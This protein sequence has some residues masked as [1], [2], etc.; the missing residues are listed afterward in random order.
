MGLMQTFRRRMPVVIIFLIVMFVALFIY[1]WGY[2]RSG[3][4]QSGGTSTTAIASVNGEDISIAE[5]NE[6]VKNAIEA[7]RGQNA[8]APV[9]EEQI[10]E[11]VWQQLVNQTIIR[12]AAERLGV[13]VS[14]EELVQT[15]LYDPPA[16]LKQ[17]F[18]DST[19][20]FFMQKE[21]MAFMTNIDGWLAARK[22]PQN[23]IDEVKAQIKEIERN[24]MYQK[25]VEAVM[26]V[27]SSSATPSPLEARIAYSDQHEKVSGGFV[28]FDVNLIPDSAVSVTEQEAKAYYDAHRTDFQQKASREARYTLFQLTPSANDSNVMSNRLKAVTD[29]INRAATPEEKTKAF[30]QFATKY[31]S[32]TYNGVEYTPLQQLSPELQTALANAV[33]GSVIGPVRLADGSYMINVVDVKDSG[34]VYVKASHI[35][36]R[37][38]GANDDSVKAEAERI[39][40]L[41][42]GGQDFGSLATQY[43]ADPGSAQRGGDLPFFKKGSMLKEFEDASFAAQPGQIVGPVKT[44]VGYH[45]IKVTDRSSKSYR[46]RDMKFDPKVSPMTK[47]QLRTKA[48]QFR[49]KLLAG[50][51]IDTLA[52]QLK[53]QVLETGPAERLTPA[54]G[55]MRFTRFIFDE[56]Q[57]AISDVYELQDGSFL[58]GQISKIRTAGTQDFADAKDAIMMKLRAKKKLDMVKGRAEKMRAALAAGDSLSK[59]AS[60]DSS[61]QVRPINEA[62]RTTPFPGVGFDYTL[63]NALFSMKP[64]QI[65]NALRGERGYFIATVSNITKPSDKDYEAER[66]KFI[67][68]LMQQRRQQIFQEWM[69]K[70]RDRAEIIDY[71]NNR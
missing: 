48:Q 41:A 5:Y 4:G 52:T 53:L 55:S 16:A 59:L 33:P 40:K 71:R 31:G 51:N 70:E 21:Y 7:Q 67:E 45:I 66:T 14:K 28:M 42:R 22:Y 36:L 29:G 2:E 50:T 6:Q 61:L 15:M 35:L 37:T 54:A 11:Q 47:A 64:G 12:Q 25:T 30:E 68:G 20:S 49:D 62:T 69:Q 18:M 43:S 34:E 60:L 44:S 9:N 1:E 27:V 3:R 56:K 46:L 63:T 23:K 17:P 58:V 39:L 65:S 10:R 38:G 8:D 26:A 24:V 13:G 19:G 57:G 32:G